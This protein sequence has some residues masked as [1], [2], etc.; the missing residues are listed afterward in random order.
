M[1]DQFLLFKRFE[2]WIY[3]S[4]YLIN[5]LWAEGT[6]RHGKLKQRK[7]QWCVYCVHNFLYIL[8]LF[9][10]IECVHF[11]V[12]C[13]FE[14]QILP[15]NIELYI[16]WRFSIQHWVRVLQL[17]WFLM[18]WHLDRI[19]AKEK[20][21]NYVKWFRYIIIVILNLLW[22]IWMNETNRNSS[23]KHHCHRYLRVRLSTKIHIHT[24]IITKQ[25]TN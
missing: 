19:N 6:A 1:R 16:Q 11:R 2:T 21:N 12:F 9:V 25:L 14:H 23:A 8:C 13:L 20:C 3:V 4:C 18:E 5:I 7:A 17:R 24:H 22:K 10:F 15:S